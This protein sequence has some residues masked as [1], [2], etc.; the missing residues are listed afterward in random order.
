M[1]VLIVEDAEEVVESFRICLLMRWPDCETQAVPTAAGGV[2]LA[3]DWSPDLVLLDV[4][5]PDSSGLNALQQLR[6]F[7]NVPVIIVS[8]QGDEA[9][10]ARGLELGA[11]DYLP[12][13]FAHTELLARINAVLRRVRRPEAASGH[14]L[15]APGLT[16]DLAAGR[17]SVNGADQ[18]LSDIEWRLLSY[19]ARN[20]GRILPLELVARNVWGEAYVEQAAIRMC[21]HRLRRKLGDDTR[22]P[23]ILVSHRGRGYS[24][25]LPRQAWP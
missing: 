16:I 19:L 15:H 1:K 17:V 5:L 6:R 18:A 9:S 13:P 2:E 11:D 14:S 21:V 10:R 23:R 24:L 22:A 20:E 7:S 25:E 12:K 4:A 8:V 3:R